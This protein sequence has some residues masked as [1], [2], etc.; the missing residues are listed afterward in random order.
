MKAANNFFIGNKRLYSL[1]SPCQLDYLT[2]QKNNKESSEISFGLDIFSAIDMIRYLSYADFAWNREDYDPTES[3]WRILVALYGIENTSELVLFND[4]FVT[5][6]EIINTPLNKT[7]ASKLK[8]AGI[9]VVNNLETHYQNL[10]EAKEINE[11]LLLELKMKMDELMHVYDD[12][13]NNIT[14]NRVNADTQVA[15]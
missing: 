1:F 10:A 9:T 5:M 8:K 12:K 14:F 13:M 6:L 4:A 2:P 11:E 7:T 15:N 3:I